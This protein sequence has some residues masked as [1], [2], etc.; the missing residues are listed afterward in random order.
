MGCLR[1]NSVVALDTSERS[2]NGLIV[3][4]QEPG[5]IEERLYYLQTIANLL[6]YVTDN[7]WA[8]LATPMA[9]P[10]QERT[11][12]A[13]I[14]Q[15]RHNPTDPK[16]HEAPIHDQ[17]ARIC[18]VI[19]TERAGDQT[20]ASLQA[21][22]LRQVAANVLQRL[23]EGP[24]FMSILQ[25]DTAD[26]ITKALSQSITRSD[27]V[28]Q[29]ALM[30]LVIVTLRARLA[31]RENVSQ[32]LH[33][34]VVSGEALKGLPRLSYSTEISDQG[35][36]TTG[37]HSPPP[38]LLDCLLSG[39]SSPHAWPVLE[40]WVQFL[41]DCLPFYAESAFQILMPLV[42]CL[43]KTIRSVFQLLRSTFEGS[44]QASTSAEPLLTL[45]SL[46][47]GLER[48]LARAHER[49]MQHEAG[50]LSIKTPEQTQGFFGNIVSGVFT[51]ETNRTRNA[52]ANNRLTVL[53]CFKDAVHTCFEIWTWGDHGM[54]TLS[55]WPPNSASFSF[56]S[57]R[58]KN[59][60]R[61]ILEHLF[62]AEALE[63]LETLIELWH[64]PPQG[65]KKEPSTAMMNLLHALEHSRPKNTIPAMFNAIYSRTNPNALDSGRKSS[66]TSDLS[67]TVVAGFLIAY[68]E[69]LE[70]DAM[71]EIWS[72]CMTFLRDVLGN[73]L[74]HRQTLPRLLEFTAILGQKV[75]NTNFGEQRG[76]RRDLGVSSLEPVSDPANFL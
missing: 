34:A 2:R 23:L 58:L 19:L 70:D 9:L 30:D 47:N 45:I 10:H 8:A 40:N 12:E 63:C 44:Y 21:S 43:N 32:P 67:D 29:V 5:D 24:A 57:V 52:S 50:T 60:L 4:A 11:H 68:M 20:G 17:L 36:S 65:Y 31:V 37:P 39:L 13:S 69:S 35:D 74:P 62:D 53:L 46:L 22:T 27:T 6:T 26:A 14:D 55:R 28:L 66:L 7:T 73:P 16:G 48:S 56:T 76:M 51:P 25:A 42:D 41:D 61:R 15:S 72:D 3:P 18:L 38:E 71:D 75:D 64:K 59:R 49:L 1:P 54:D 33:R